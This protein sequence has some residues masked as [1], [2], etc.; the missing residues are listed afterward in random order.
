MLV[1]ESALHMAIVNENQHMVHILCKNGA[2]IHERAYGAFFCPEDQRKSRKDRAGKETIV[3]TD[4]TNYER[5]I[6]KQSFSVDYYFFIK[7]NCV[8]LKVLVIN[9]S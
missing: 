6:R 4:E 2:D 8:C 9:N 3:L 5:Y 1:G 7:C